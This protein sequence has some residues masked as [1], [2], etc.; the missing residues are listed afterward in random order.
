MTDR[1]DGNYSQWPL[2][3]L[4]KKE[5]SYTVGDRRGA[6]LQAEISRRYAT[7][8]QRYR[9]VT[10]IAA[11]MTLL[12]GL[13]YGLDRGIYVGS[14]VYNLPDKDGYVW[15]K[16]EIAEGYVYKECR[17]LFITGIA[18]KPARGGKYDSIPA[19]AGTMA[20]QQP[21]NNLSQLYCRFFG[22]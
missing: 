18:G 15:V 3:E 21:V 12:G 17:Y 14:K 22:E 8:N 1:E 13:I 11:V 5:R 6:E 20:G 16:P 19:F 2:K 4:M 10:V 9:L 7:R